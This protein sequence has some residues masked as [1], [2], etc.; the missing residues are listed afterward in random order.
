MRYSQ[1][2]LSKHHHFDDQGGCDQ[3]LA[4][5]LHHGAPVFT[6]KNQECNDKISRG[7][8]LTLQELMSDGRFKISIIV[9]VQLAL[10]GL[11]LDY[12]PAW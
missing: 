2:S 6:Y 11:S 12:Y 10:V 7:S 8:S 1:R 3:G 9:H 4:F 5:A